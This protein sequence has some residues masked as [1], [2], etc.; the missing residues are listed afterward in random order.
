[1]PFGH[2]GGDD[3]GAVCA[4]APLA[5]PMASNAKPLPKAMARRINEL[6]RIQTPETLTI[7]VMRLSA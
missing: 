3:D 5:G 4:M 1:M 7:L 2:G 6:N